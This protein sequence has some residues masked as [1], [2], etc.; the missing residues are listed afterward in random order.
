MP[1]TQQM[2]PAEPLLGTSPAIRR[3]VEQ[4][5]RAALT[6]VPVLL[7]GESGTGK[8]M[9]AQIVHGLSARRNGSFIRIN[10][11]SVPLEIFESKLFGARPAADKP[12]TP[13]TGPCTEPYCG[14]LFLDEIAELDLPLQS[15]LLR[16]LNG[17]PPT[18]FGTPDGTHAEVRLVCATNH[19]LEDDVAAG[20]LRIDLFHR[21]DVLRIEMP[22]LRDRIAD[23]RILMEHFVRTYGERFSRNPPPLRA[24]FLKLLECY[25]WPGNVR[26]LENMAKRYVLLGGEEHLVPVLR[27]IA[28]APAPAVD[29]VTPLRVQTR[30]AVQH[31]ERNV[32]LNALQSNAWNRTRTARSLGISYRVLLH[33]I[34]EVGLPSVRTSTTSADD[35][36]VQDR[37]EGLC[38]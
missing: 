7:T 1:D 2:R 37:E 28:N 10:C 19:N 12:A 35:Y 26:E 13:S 25:H 6:D 27:G 16:A 11:P 34:K 22:A 32:I 5:K 21:V 29:L 20:K 31:L 24:A 23:V 38:P 36:A 4:L 9:S 15:H 3:V 17:F 18:R 33:K 14:T 8:E 30:R